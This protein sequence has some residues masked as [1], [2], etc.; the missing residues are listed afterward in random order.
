[1]KIKLA[2]AQISPALGDFAKN[3]ALHADWIAQAQQQHV[4]LLVFPELSLTGYYLKDLVSQVALQSPYQK[5]LELSQKAVGMDLV[6]GF[7]ERAENQSHYI[8]AGYMSQSKMLH[9]HRKCY[10]PTYGIFD[11]TRFFGAGS[12]AQVFETRFG[13]VG[14]LICEDAWHFPMAYL[15]ALQGAQIII[16]ISSSPGTG[17]QNETLISQQKWEALNA[18]Y[19]HLFGVYMVYVNRVGVEDGIQFWGGSHV[20]APGGTLVGSAKILEPELKVLEID[21]AQISRS[22]EALPLLRDEKIDWTIA[23]LQAIRNLRP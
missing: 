10:L 4:D 6:T 8:A 7:V 13:K 11:D 12:H 1:M 16:N 5:I 18:A 20:F 14:I 15:L 17:V 9:V 19:A 3:H 2:L 23:Q 22:R 21:L